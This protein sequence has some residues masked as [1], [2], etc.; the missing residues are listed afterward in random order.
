MRQEIKLIAV[1]PAH[2]NSIR[3]KKKVLIDIL[4]LPMIEHVRRR[5]LNSNIFE[6]VII[7]SG[8]DEILKLIERYGGDTIKTYQKHNN[9]TSRVS[10]AVKDLKYTHIVIIQGDEPLIKKEHLLKI[11]K[12]IINNPSLDAWNSITNLNKS[13]D[14]DNENVVK[15]SINEK[16]KIIYLFRKTPSY[17]DVSDQLIYIKKIQG[18]IA[19][20]REVLEKLSLIPPSFGEK[21]ES[22]EQLRIVYNGYHLQGV[23]QDDQVPSINEENDLKDLYKYLSENKDQNEFT[24]YI[25]NE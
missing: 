5:V 1:I 8:D 13:E 21:F 23:M 7:A 11:S 3:L 9:G 2:L 10:E 22:I 14:L 19:F 25:L 4:G 17:A 15:A 24:K 20:R 18:L 12:S 16:E 6:R